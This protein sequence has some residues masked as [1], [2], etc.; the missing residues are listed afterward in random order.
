MSDSNSQRLSA[1]VRALISGYVDSYALLN[2]GVYASFM[3]GNTTT[4]GLHAG[5]ANLAAAGHSL[6]P[7]PFFLLGILA[8]SLVVRLDHHHALRRISL[9][10]AAML[11]VAA[12]RAYFAW[13]GWLGIM[14]LSSAMGLLNTSVTQVGGQAVSLGFMTGDLNN[15]AQ[16][17]ALQELLLAV[18]H[19]GEQ[20]ERIEAAILELLPKWSLAPVVEALQALRGINLVTAAT[21]M[22]EIGDLQRFENPRQLMAYLGLVPGERS[23]G[24]TVHRLGITKAGN[25]RVR[26]A[27][28]ESAWSYRHPPR[29]SRNKHYIH[30][31]LPPAVRDIA[32]K[33]RTRLCAR[34]R[35]L[36]Q[37]GKKLT[38]T[39]T[40]IARELAG[41]IWAIGRE[42][43][44]A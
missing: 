3:T 9:L 22:A 36:S 14:L 4:G 31:N 16:H 34:Y 44:A 17:L 30:E 37:R 35:A 8:G 21:V 25:G 5:Q 18:R 33:A 6:L 28:V 41:F 2:F 26:Q 24:D 38:V 42:V 20:L 19:A 40:A 39:V 29:T 15:L 43:Q 7:I 1:L 27:L 23:T 32:A 12:A 11:A 13:P 10:V